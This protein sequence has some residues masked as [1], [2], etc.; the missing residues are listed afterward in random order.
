MLNYF[1]N[2]CVYCNVRLT[3][4]N[5]YDNTLHI[6][7]YRSL[8]E[9]DDGDDYQILEGLTVTN[10]LPS[11]RSCNLQKRDVNPEIWIRSYIPNAD[12]ILVKIELYFCKQQEGIFI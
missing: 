3:R 1:D 11:C 8:S 7:H 5:G 4:E 12:E 6:D 2:R 9:Q 10:A